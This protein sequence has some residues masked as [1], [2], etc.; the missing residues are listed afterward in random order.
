M[1]LGFVNQTLVV[2]VDGI[3]EAIRIAHENMK[4]GSLFTGDGQLL[5]ANI[6]RS[7]SAYK[8]NPKNETKE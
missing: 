3:L 7:P 2:T 8:M 4:G 6:N 1:S 5:D